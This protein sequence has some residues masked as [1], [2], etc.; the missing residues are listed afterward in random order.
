LRARRDGVR[1]IPLR[2]SG[3]HGLLSILVALCLAGVAG[4]A[5]AEPTPAAAAPRDTVSVVHGLALPQAVPERLQ[6]QHL[7]SPPLSG[8]YGVLSS[9]T[10]QAASTASS[11]RPSV[12][13]P[14]CGSTVPPWAGRAPPP[15]L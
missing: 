12:A 11:Y 13:V 5:A 9:G 6:A 15:L 7:P 1:R 14:C 3:R 10:S 2:G 4:T 8:G